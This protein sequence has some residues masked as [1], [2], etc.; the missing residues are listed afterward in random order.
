MHAPQAVL[1]LIVRAAKYLL[2]GWL[3]PAV[4]VGS[5][6]QNGPGEADAERPGTTVEYRVEELADTDRKLAGR[7]TAAQLS[8]LEKLNR[9][10][11]KNLRRLPQL[12]VPLTWHAEDWRYSPF[13]LRHAPAADVPKLL[14]ADQASQAFAAYESGSL[15]R[16]GPF[17]SGRRSSPTPSG[18]FRLN[19]RSQGRYSTVNPTWYMKWYFNFESR[20]GLA[21]HE[22]VLPGYPASHACIRLLA[23]DAIWLY[24]WGV[25]SMS[26][27]GRGN[28]GGT[29]VI[30]VGQYDFDAPPPWR[31]LAHLARGIDLPEI[32]LSLD[33]R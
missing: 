31:S 15:V 10:D 17:S 30:V 14:V 2:I 25:A 21:L 13:P 19:W 32:A 18:V 9:A 22:Y 5:P 28:D 4:A 24:H 26:N 20:G 1:G 29:P 6:G 12:V 11:V 16:W 27:S 23:R 33:A 7:F 8:I 3:A